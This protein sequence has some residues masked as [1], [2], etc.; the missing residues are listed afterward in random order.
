MASR[1]PPF[2]FG[3]R[4]RTGRDKLRNA[5]TFYGLPPF[6]QSQ[7]KS[8]VFGIAGGSGKAA[9]FIGTSAELMVRSG[10]SGFHG[11]GLRSCVA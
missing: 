5:L 9:A 6:N 10:L 3:S 4:R 2:P 8:P 1:S 7:P 11:K